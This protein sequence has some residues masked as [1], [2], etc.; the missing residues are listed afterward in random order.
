MFFVFVAGGGHPRAVLFYQLAKF[1]FLKLLH[2]LF[3]VARFASFGG[4]G[5]MDA[6]T[7]LHTSLH[8]SPVLKPFFLTNFHA[9]GMISFNWFFFCVLISFLFCVGGNEIDMNPE[10]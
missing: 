1:I 10:S 7:L 9:R 5:K 2:V 6:F 3:C 4:G 8:A